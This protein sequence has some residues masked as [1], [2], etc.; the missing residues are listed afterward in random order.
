MNVILSIKPKYVD[1]IFKGEKTFEYRKS[2]FK[3]NDIEKV[4]IYSSSPVMKVVG[5][6]KIKDIYCANPDEIWENTKLESGIDETFFRKYFDGK[7]KAFAIKINNLKQYKD[8]YDLFKSFGIKP[9]QSF[10]YVDNGIT[11]LCN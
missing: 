10:A 11:K 5:E 9:P 3:R 2:I 8:E 1:K 7:D 4:I 6:F